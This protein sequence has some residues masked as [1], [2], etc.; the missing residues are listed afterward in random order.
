MELHHVSKVPPDHKKLCV[1]V[2]TNPIFHFAF[3][4]S[5][6]PWNHWWA[7]PQKIL[8]RHKGEWVKWPHLKVAEHWCGKPTSSTKGTTHHISILVLTNRKGVPTWSV[9]LLQFVSSAEPNDVKIYA[10]LLESFPEGFSWGFLLPSQESATLVH[11]SWAKVMEVGGIL[12]LAVAPAA[13]FVPWSGEFQTT[14]WREADP[15]GRS[16][17]KWG[18][19]LTWKTDILRRFDIRFG[20]KLFVGGGDC[21]SAEWS[22]P[23]NLPVIQTTQKD[24]LLEQ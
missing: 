1:P 18:K 21:H 15:N 16:H 9:L 24:S 2:A 5:W 20:M 23:L 10:E 19:H 13:S 3:L 8:L 11:T 22:L 6:C 17:F 14:L 4:W 12:Q 7:L